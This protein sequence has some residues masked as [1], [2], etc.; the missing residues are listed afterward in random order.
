MTAIDH[1]RLAWEARTSSTLAVLGVLF[2]IAY[3]VY[4][5]VVEPS[6][7]LFAAILLVGLVSWVAFAVDMVARTA[8]SDRGRRVR[9]LLTHPLDVLALFVPLFRAL[10]VAGLLRYIPMLRGRSG[11]AVRGSV[12]AHALVYAVVYVY[13]I[14]LATLQVE[15]DAPDATITTFADAVWWAVVTLATV[16]YGDTYP[17]TGPGRFLAVLLMGGG[18]VIVGTA[19]AIVVSYITERVGNQRAAATGGSEAQP[20]SSASSAA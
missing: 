10:R 7:L 3:S 11:A 17:V 14:A 6:D 9:F 13:V 15:R 16:G 12:V 5:L 19:S 2:L 20:S 4:V 18:I 8:L 1:R